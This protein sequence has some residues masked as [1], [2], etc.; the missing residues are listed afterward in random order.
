MD[1]W[2]L[3]VFT[4]LAGSGTF[5][6]GKFDSASVGAGLPGV[7]NLTKDQIGEIGALVLHGDEIVKAGGTADQSAA[8]Q[9]AIWTTEY[10]SSPFAY[11]LTSGN[12]TTVTSLVSQ[13]LG[14]VGPSP[15]TKWGEY[16]GLDTLAGSQTLG[17]NQTL[18][19][20]PEASTWAMMLAGFAG[21]GYAAFHR[22]GKRTPVT[23]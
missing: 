7:P 4:Y 8:I 15:V 6:V 19:T 23:S 2:C 11:D 18:L 14:D 22:T 17:T 20:V 3:D 13:Y 12:V 16:F 21:L 1:A 10:T 5:A 9:I